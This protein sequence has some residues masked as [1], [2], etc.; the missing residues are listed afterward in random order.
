MLPG[1]K[2]MTTGIKCGMNALISQC[3]IL[4]P[5]AEKMVL[6]ERNSIPSIK[7]F[8]MANEL[9]DYRRYC[10]IYISHV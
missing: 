3:T 8:G 10:H 1:H 7:D 5:K 2:G 6:Q 9:V 4:C